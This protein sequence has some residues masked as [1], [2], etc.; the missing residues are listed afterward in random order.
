MEIEGAKLRNY[1]QFYKRKQVLL[2][3]NQK[4]AKSDGA[5]PFQSPLTCYVVAVKN[6]L[7]VYALDKNLLSKSA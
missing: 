1:R 4:K 2:P 5:T 6:P 3:A 7:L